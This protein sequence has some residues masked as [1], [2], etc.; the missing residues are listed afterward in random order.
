MNSKSTKPL[1]SSAGVLSLCFLITGCVGQRIAWSP[2]GAQAAIFA[3]D[4]LRL[5]GP[6]GA[7]SEVVLPGEGIAQWFPDS[8]RL[9]VLSELGGQSWKEVDKIL[10]AE[11]RKRVV[12]AAR[13]LLEQLK[14]GHNVSDGLKAL[15]GFGEYEGKA[16]VA[17]LAQSD[18]AKS[19]PET[20]REE[21]HPND[22]AVIRVQVGAV[23]NGKLVLGSTVVTTLRKILDIRVSPT[24]MAISLTMEGDKE[25]SADL[26]VAPVDGSGPPQ[27][28]SRNTAVYSDWSTDGH[29]LVYLAAAKSYGAAKGPPADD[30]ISLGSL[31]R[32]AVLNAAN[33]IEIQEKAED[34]AGMLFE[35]LNKVRCLSGGRIVFAAA[36]VHLPCTA[37]D[38]P[39]Q[40]QLYVLDPERQKAVI[41]LIPRG[42]Q[43]RLPSKP[44]FYE[45]SPDGNRIA[46]L[47]EQGAVAIFT[48]ATGD[49]KTVV[50][51]GNGDAIS[52]PA[53]RSATELCFIS[54]TEG[55][56]QQVA[57]WKDGKA[58]VLSAS[59]PAAARKG[60]LDK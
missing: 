10:S 55:Q 39:Q 32:R 28:V 27:L 11:E 12:E 40:P 41:P 1:W 17:Y 43:E 31:S 15:T 22:A 60:F 56:A 6:D 36:E 47:G 52:A 49:L 25:D 42:V 29:S 38:M 57:M 20:A 34:L 54:S 46:I 2:D 53:W 18:E 3:G 33:K 8:H 58:R 16:A 44:C 45:V 9:A 4:G 21:L 7:L 50:S 26:L 14:A 19:L 13:I 35:T 30:P 24:E 23:E 59:W 5:C 51:P 48:P 37:L